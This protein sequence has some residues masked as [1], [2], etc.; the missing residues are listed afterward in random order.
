MKRRLSLLLLGLWLAGALATAARAAAPEPEVKAAV[1]F[2]LLAFVQWPGEGQAADRQLRF[3]IIDGGAL[4]A[5]L[6]RFQ[7]QSVR[8][9]ELAV[10]RTPH[11]EDLRPCHAVLVGVGNP[12]ALARAAA[13]ARGQA[14]LVIGEGGAAI[15]QGAMVGVAVVGG[16]VAFDV[17]LGALRR[18][19][20]VI[21]SKVLRLA[22][23]VV[24]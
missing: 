6:L 2:N 17:D 15:E 22:R 23:S 10:Q 24:E 7:G 3:C 16:R 11:G 1:I 19:Q 21:S 13:A 4:E 9:G 20:L 5:A 18:A 12:A 14:L 8:G